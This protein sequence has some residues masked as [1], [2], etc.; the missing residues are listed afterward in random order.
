MKNVIES[1][2]LLIEL[3]YIATIRN[4]INSRRHKARFRK[5]YYINAVRVVEAHN[6]S[7]SELRLLN[8]SRSQAKIQSIKSDMDWLRKK[9]PNPKKWKSMGLHKL[10]SIV[11]LNEAQYA[12]AKYE[13]ME[14]SIKY[15]NRIAFLSSHADCHIV[16]NNGSI[17]AIYCFKNKAFLC[18]EEIENY[19]KEFELVLALDDM[20][21]N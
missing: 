2:A 19:A 8:P 12:M 4:S 7:N 6:E 20:L 15:R 13:T 21:R 1:H 16:Y 18:I 3:C 10:R 17:N 14:F 5:N 9:H 11:L